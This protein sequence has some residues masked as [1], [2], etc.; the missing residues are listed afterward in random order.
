MS[1]RGRRPRVDQTISLPRS[2]RLTEEEL[3]ALKS[4]AQ[5]VGVGWT[6]FVREAALSAANDLSL[7]GDGY[8]HWQLLH[9]IARYLTR[10]CPVCEGSGEYSEIRLGNSYFQTAPCYQCSPVRILLGLDKKDEHGSS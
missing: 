7:L 5:R 4:A 3:E 1:P 8:E 10:D 9:E 2:L 6:V